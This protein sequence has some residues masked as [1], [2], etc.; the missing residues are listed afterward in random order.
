MCEILTQPILEQVLAF[1][2]VYLPISHLHMEHALHVFPLFSHLTDGVKNEEFIF[3]LCSNTSSIKKKK[4]ASCICIFRL[5]YGKPHHQSPYICISSTINYTYCGLWQIV[6]ENPPD[7]WREEGASW[8]MEAPISIYL[9][10]ETSKR[11]ILASPSGL[12][13][14]QAVISQ[15]Q[16]K[17][18]PL[19]P[20]CLACVSEDARSER[21]S[22][23]QT[24]SDCRLWEACLHQP[25]R[26][27]NLTIIM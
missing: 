2:F 4:K 18:S 26:R 14:M 17:Q 9:K 22:F 1:L 21:L 20:D 23:P 16:P 7:V 25:T 8:F 27:Q 6:C 5:N 15:V 12:G 10:R 24:S 13:P 3:N 19:S 11:S